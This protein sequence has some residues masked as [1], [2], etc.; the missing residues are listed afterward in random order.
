MFIHRFRLPT[1]RRRPNP[2]LLSADKYETDGLCQ[3]PKFLSVK[4]RI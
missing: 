3:L 4:K 1:G 2:P